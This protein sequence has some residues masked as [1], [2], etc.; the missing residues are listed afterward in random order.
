MQEREIHMKALL[1]TLLATVATMGAA[2][3]QTSDALSGKAYIGIGGTTVKNEVVDGYRFGEKIFGGYNFDQNWAAEAGYTRFDSANRGTTETNG[4]NS[5]IAAKYS[6]PI[7]DQFSGYAKLGVSR[8]VRKVSDTGFNYRGSDTGAYG[9]L[10]V[11]YKLNQNMA[12]N[13]EYERNGKQKDL[14][15]KADSLGLGLSYGF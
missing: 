11:Q 3:A 10:G 13:L 12:L 7:N 2:Q 8:A 6:M 4:Y 5:Y 9:A 14:G 1:V 15:A